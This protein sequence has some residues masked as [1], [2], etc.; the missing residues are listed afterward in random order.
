MI[1]ALQ[2]KSCSEHIQ[3]LADDKLHSSFTLENSQKKLLE[4]RRSSQQ[5]QESLEDLQSK[6]EK[7]RVTVVEMQIE[8]ERER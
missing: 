5:A 3:K 1:L 4:M 7:S 2:L 8:L 6:G